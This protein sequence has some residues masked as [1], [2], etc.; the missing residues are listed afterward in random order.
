MKL[1]YSSLIILT[2]LFGCSKE[3][4]LISTREVE[5]I[6]SIDSR[7]RVAKKLTIHTD[8]NGI[9]YIDVKEFMGLLNGKL[10]FDRTIV[11]STLKLE[12]VKAEAKNL[13]SESDALS[14]HHWADF[15]VEENTINLSSS[16]FA[17]EIIYGDGFKNYTVESKT[18]GKKEE[19]Q[20]NLNNYSMEL[21]SV[22]NRTLMPF[23][24]ANMMFNQ[25]YYMFLLND[26]IH[27]LDIGRYDDVYSLSEENY[28]GVTEF[29]LNILRLY[30][31]E[32]YGL[33]QVKDMTQV[34]NILSND[35]LSREQRVFDV[36]TFLDD[37]HT[38]LFY[39]FIESDT[40]DF[41]TYD[42]AGKSF[43]VGYVD[44]FMYITINTFYFL[45]SSW[46]DQILKDT[47]HYENIVI[48]VSCNRGG[49][50]SNIYDL[51]SNL[52]SEK[53][54]VYYIRGNE[55]IHYILNSNK[56][57]SD[58]NE[59]YLVTSNFTYSAG[60]T[61]ANLMS[62]NNIATLVGN[63]TAGGA[64]SRFDFV[65]PSNLVLATSSN[66][67]ST[68]EEGILTENGVMPDILLSVDVTNLNKN[69]IV[70]IIKA[71]IT[72]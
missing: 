14:S 21:F 38:K 22:N 60:N 51:I 13:V 57:I 26:E 6:N 36:I 63:E 48:D 56:S 61:L 54:D 66:Q 43:K 67:C 18:F 15:D 25:S 52:T 10:I 41:C 44:E 65:L 46:Y 7:Y 29:D 55:Q 8:R 30:F 12:Y 42:P 28:S 49:Y 68:N 47:K 69:E 19:L 27:M 62:T 2:I 1:F 4:S 39:P 20:I 40:S 24:L 16:D 33:S 3:N 17:N 53:I 34:D 5:I 31:D 23:S 58:K 35:E 37:S 70:E 9:D 50:V 11:N 64:C 59:I 32:F 71:N 45:E 72:T